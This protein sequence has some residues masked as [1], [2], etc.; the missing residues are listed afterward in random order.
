MRACFRAVV[1]MLKQGQLWLACGARSWDN[2]GRIMTVNAALRSFYE[3][4]EGYEKGVINSKNVLRKVFH[5]VAFRRR[6]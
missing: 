3:W 6:A 5:K 1:A 2:V 4:R